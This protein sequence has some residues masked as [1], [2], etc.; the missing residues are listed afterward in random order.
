MA[1]PGLYLQTLFFFN[2][3]FAYIIYKYIIF[4]IL[5][6]TVN[7]ETI[8]HNLY[9]FTRFFKGSRIPHKPHIIQ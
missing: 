4:P 3:F 6:L 5:E 9:V 2:Q 8:Y 7:I 1:N